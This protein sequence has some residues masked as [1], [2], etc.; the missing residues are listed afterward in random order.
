MPTVRAMWKMK[1]ALSALV[2]RSM[3]QPTPPEYRQRVRRAAVLDAG[4]GAALF[5]EQVA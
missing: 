3:G 2:Q 5:L 4:S 1:T